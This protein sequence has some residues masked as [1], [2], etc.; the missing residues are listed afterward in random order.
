MGLQPKTAR[1]LRGDDYEEVPIEQIAVGDLLQVRPG[2]KIPVDG[3]V[4]DGSSFIDE[5]MITGE[6]VPV[7][8][9]PGEDVVGGTI[10]KTG[11]FRFRAERV[12]ADTVLAQIIRMVESAQGAKL[13]IQ[14]LVDRVTAWF[15]PAVMAVAVVTTLVWLVFGPVPAMTF[16]LVNAVAVLIIACPCA[17]GLAT[18]TSIMVGTGR[19]AEMGVLFRNGEALQTLRGAGVIALDKTGT[20]TA[21]KPVL[22]DLVGRGAAPPPPRR[23]RGGGGPAGAGRPPGPAGG[24]ARGGAPP[25]APP[26]PRGA[27]PVLSTRRGR[28]GSR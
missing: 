18:P 6:P 11:A 27:R 10:N 2:E 22:T 24:G 4:V 17:M 7:A 3:T 16:A 23:G 26:P 13:P 1:V 21:G 5:S 19:G 8:K 14:A 15:V 9:G 25:A 12:G 28:G 20:L